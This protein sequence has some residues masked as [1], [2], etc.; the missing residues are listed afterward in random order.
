MSREDAL[1]LMR[2]FVV[3]DDLGTP[4]GAVFQSRQS[5]QSGDDALRDPVQPALTEKEP[6]PPEGNRRSLAS[7]R[8]GPVPGRCATRVLR[9]STWRTR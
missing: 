5:G 9:E 2:K 7:R 6:R 1:L 3:P 4:P 8:E